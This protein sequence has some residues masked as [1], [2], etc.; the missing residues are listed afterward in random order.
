MFLEA[1]ETEEWMHETIKRR[2]GCLD[3]REQGQLNDL[4]PG[5]AE[6]L[7]AASCSVATATCNGHMRRIH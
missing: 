6:T 5:D 2:L 7:A 1:R 3:G 4:K